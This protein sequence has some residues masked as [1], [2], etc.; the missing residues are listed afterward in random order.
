MCLLPQPV[1][2]ISNFPRDLKIMEIFINITFLLLLF[3]RISLALAQNTTISINVGVVLDLDN[4]V[5]KM[6]LSCINMALSDF[7]ASHAYYRTRLVLH[8][9]DSSKDVVVAAA[10]A[11]ELINSV[12]V[13]A[14][15]G[16]ESSMQASFVTEL[17]DKAQA[18]QWSEAVPI[19]VDNE[20]GKGI[21]PYLTT[22]LQAVGARIP[23]WVVIPQ[24]ATADQ[25]D[26]EL[27]KLMKMQIRVFIVHMLPSLGTR[28]FAR[29][30]ELGMMDEGFAWIVTNAISNYYGSLDS[31][32]IDNMQGVLGL[33][34]YVP[35]TKD[36]ENFRGRW[37]KRFQQDN[38]T[39]SS[40][41]LNVFGLWAYDAAWSL[42][43]AVEKVNTTT[44]NFKNMNISAGSSTG[45]DRLEISQS[46]PK[47]VQELS[48]TRFI[49]LSGDFSLLDRQLQSSNFQVVNVN[50]NG[51]RGIGYWTPQNGLVRNL[52]SKNTST[53]I[54]S[55]GPVIW[56]GDTTSAPKGWQIPTGGK[57]KVLVP[58]KI[59]FLEFVNASTD[60]TTNTTVFSGYCI[61]VFN[62]VMKS[63]PYSVP[64]EFHPFAKPNSESAGSYNDLVYLVF[65]GKYDAA[66]G[67]ITIRANR[68][69]Y[70][71]FTLPYTESG[72]SM[73]VPVTDN[74]VPKSTWVF[75][76]PFTLELWVTSGCFF[77]F[78]GF[79]VWVLEHQINDDFRG[80]PRQQMG[81]SLW[82]SFSTMVFAHRER[83]VS[84]MAR[85]VVITWCFVVLILTQSYTASF[86]SILTVQQ[87]QKNVT[88]VN[89]LLKDGKNVG[90]Q[91]GSFVL[92][93][94]KQLGFQEDKLR[95]YNTTEELN[96]LLQLGTENNG[97]SAA[98]DETPYLKLL[99][100]TY[101]SKYTM[102]EPTF[103]ADAFAFAFQKGSLLTRY[104]S[105]AIEITD[106]TKIEKKWF[107]RAGCSNSNSGDPS[108]N[109]TPTVDSFWGLFIIA[110]VVSSLALLIFAAMFFYD[111][112]HTLLNL[113]P[114]TTY[115]GRIRVMLRI[116]D[117]RDPTSYTYNMR[118]LQDPVHCLSADES[119]PKTTPPRPSSANHIESH[120]VVE[121][122]FG[123][124]HAG[125]NPNPQATQ[126]TEGAI[127]LT[128]HSEQGPV[129]H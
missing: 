47:L 1:A 102:V 70:V 107:D 9:R 41:S 34:A 84:N 80:P 111:H 105:D 15:I 98:F 59:G 28:L 129:P 89:Q 109:L 95:V 17:G 113:D 123:T 69:L 37:Q 97:I 43:I 99:L 67:D 94:L 116:Y 53:F 32:F 92:G 85:F 16:P 40:V 5:G 11:L 22:A 58:V 72:I 83:V 127:E 52:N 103:N 36:L 68:S 82:Y 38:S 79:V 118:G 121:Q 21:I 19:T 128:S 25:I 66:V 117:Q 108:N 96:E 31:S 122:H 13:Q 115:W 73:V 60:P 29:A 56:P 125:L 88:D 93:T 14:I 27:D 77:I 49:G 4:P 91:S 39:L 10:A 112:R 42:A 119:L 44:F 65:L 2:S 63:M 101:C 104:I 45:L 24:M 33:K 35:N 81:T 54:A 87:L 106:M 90:Y 114:K 3:F 12:K 75:L 50:D 120:I 76:K 86:S 57:L 78:V 8:T 62:A 126:K 20:F 71:D 64:Y 30:K 26:E 46:G 55:L 74:N 48:S 124:E 110:G 51:E 7:Y 23:Y 61:D 100:A 6:G 18:F